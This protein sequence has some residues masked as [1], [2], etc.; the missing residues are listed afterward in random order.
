MALVSHSLEEMVERRADRR[1]QFVG[2][3]PTLRR[4]RECRTVKWFKNKRWKRAGT[5]G[6][7][8]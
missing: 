3:K 5:A 2:P 1:G 4:R 6:C 8:C 7:C